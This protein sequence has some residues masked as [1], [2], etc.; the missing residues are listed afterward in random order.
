MNDTWYCVVF[1]ITFM[2]LRI[3]KWLAEGHPASKWP[4][5]DSG[6][7]FHCSMLPPKCSIRV[8]SAEL[9]GKMKWIRAS[10]WPGGVYIKREKLKSSP[11][12]PRFK[13]QLRTRTHFHAKRIAQS[14]VESREM[15][16][17]LNPMVWEI[18]RDKAELKHQE[19]IYAHKFSQGHF[20]IQALVNQHAALD[21][22]AG[23]VGFR[24]QPNC[25]PATLFVMDWNSQNCF[26]L[27][28]RKAIQIGSNKTGICS[29][30]YILKVWVEVAFRH[31]L[32]QG[33]LPGPWNL[34]SLSFSWSFVLG[35]AL[36]PCCTRLLSSQE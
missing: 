27:Y 11:R 21:S 22:T 4:S 34:I 26:S 36:A 6:P 32:I 14:N 16:S 18:L 13:D 29:D 33:L 9:C 20:G 35:Q 1:I 19:K 24:C 12:L 15:H 17:G 25:S 23:N 2:R 8:L 28:E 31:R 7:L 5:Q 30:S 3:G 10:P